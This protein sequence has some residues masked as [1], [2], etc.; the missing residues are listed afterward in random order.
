MNQHWKDESAEAAI[1]GSISIDGPWALLEEFS[2]LTR[3]SGSED[4][5]RAAKYITA[6]L[7]EYDV[8]YEVHHPTT[9]ISLPGPA[10]L[11]TLGDGGREYR[12]KTTSFS[13][14]TG[15][16]EVT[17]ELVYVPG[18][19]AAGMTELFG[20]QR[21]A[22]DIDLSGKSRHDRRARHRRAGL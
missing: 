8:S 13:P 17:A 5:E 4:E 1:L 22:A 7:D 9:L 21:H 12:I 10:S 14:Q 11:K 2:Q 18:Q 3:L 15:G 16:E 19:Q 6:R 20:E